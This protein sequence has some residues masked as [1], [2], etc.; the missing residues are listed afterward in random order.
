MGIFDF[1]K[2]RAKRAKIEKHFYNFPS[3]SPSELEKNELLGL[4]NNANIN[5]YAKAISHQARSL[6]VNNPIIS[7]YL[8]T[9]KSEILGDRGITLDLS[10]PNKELNKRIEGSFALWRGSSQNGELDFYD[11][12][13]L[14]LIYLLRD[15]ECFLHL[16]ESQEGLRV[17]IIDNHN[18]ASD[19]SDE[20]QGIAFGIKK[21]AKNNPISYFVYDGEGRLFEVNAKAILHL[22]KKLDI[23]QHRGLSDFASIITPAHQKD[24]FRSAE[25]RKARLQSE[26]TGFIIKNN[27]DLADELLNG[28]EEHKKSIQT[29]V[30]VGKMT[31]IDEDVK[32]IFTESHNAANME[33]FITQT[34]REIAKGLGISYATL[35][36]NL[37]DVNYSSIRHGGSEQ[38]RQFRRLQNFLVRKMHNK[39]YERWLLNELKL[40]KLSTKEYQDALL[41]YS[42]KPQGWEYIDPYKETNANALAIHTGQKTL[43]EILRS[44][45]KELDTHIEELKK[46]KELQ[47]LLKELGRGN[48]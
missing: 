18:I 34:D 15:G 10:T 33:S 46:E 41:Y 21:D 14:A 13:S 45:G 7:G 16:S 5:D 6:S 2:K 28:E 9:I 11:I 19:F 47:K 32:P 20:S 23:R 12:E 25:L 3:L 1:F 36:G 31:Y 42:F 8:K 27:S 43:S 38:R 22:H 30:E 44:T 37:T 4:L 40:C 26:I 24:K 29:S 39:I 35:T 17:E 48:G